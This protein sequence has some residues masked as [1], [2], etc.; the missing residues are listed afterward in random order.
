MP[1]E[2]RARADV[3]FEGAELGI[4]RA[5]EQKRRGGESVV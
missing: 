4:E 3:A 1:S 5:R 2:D